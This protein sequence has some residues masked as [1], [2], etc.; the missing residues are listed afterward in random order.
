[1]KWLSLIGTI[2]ADI[3]IKLF[4]QGG[5]KHSEGYSDGTTEERLKDKIKKDGW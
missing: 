5:A 4:R 2:L 1:M 3:I